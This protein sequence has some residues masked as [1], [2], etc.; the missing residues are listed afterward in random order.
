MTATRKT[1]III[2]AL[3][4]LCFLV[5]CAPHSE[6]TSNKMPDYNAE[7]K[8]VFLVSYIGNDFG[9][10]FYKAFVEKVDALVGEC[11]AEFAMTTVSSLDLDPKV[12]TQKINNFRPDALLSLRHPSGTIGYSN[13]RDGIVKVIYEAELVDVVSRKP[14]LRAHFDFFK[15][16]PTRAE[17]SS[18]SY[19]G[20]ALATDLVNQL[21]K[22]GIFRSC[23]S[24]PA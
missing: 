4:F 12:H 19:I 3:C 2:P 16:S 23:A 10:D 6:T 8:R 15:G 17:L 18:K 21:K 22:D 24:P 7:P 14:A 5:G 9:G 20:E 1:G 13:T 11:G